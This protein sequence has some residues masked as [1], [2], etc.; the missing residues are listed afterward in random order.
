MQY[1]IIHQE[2]W[3][4]SVEGLP[5]EM[6]KKVH[7]RASDFRNSP[8]LLF[9]GGVHGDEPEGVRLA[10]ELLQWIQSVDAQEDLRPWILIPCLN[11]HPLWIGALAKWIKEYADGKKEMILEEMKK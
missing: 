3:S 4:R 7:T 9:I 11:V 1:E 6:Y 2:F 10:Q 8:P 5:I